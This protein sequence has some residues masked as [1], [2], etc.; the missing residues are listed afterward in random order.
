ISITSAFSKGGTV[1]QKLCSYLA[2]A[3]KTAIRRG[4]PVG[5]GLFHETDQYGRP[6]LL[7]RAN[8]KNSGR[9]PMSELWQTFPSARRRVPMT[10]QVAWISR[11]HTSR[12][13]S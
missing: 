4:L 7:L 6:R 10:W 12:K 11:W 2:A 13:Y 3:G 9:S 5:V 8:T 1:S